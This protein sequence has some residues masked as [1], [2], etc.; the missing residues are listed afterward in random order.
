MASYASQVGEVAVSVKV[1]RPWLVAVFSVVTFG[2]YGAVWYYRVNRE[3]RDFGLAHGD[4]G[5][6][7]S[8]PT[9]SVLAITIGGIVVVPELVS[10][11]RIVGRLREVERIGTGET[12]SGAGLIALLVGSMLV[13]LA[14]SVHGAPA[15][16]VLF[17]A[18]GFV[19]AF[20]L[21]QARLNAVWRAARLGR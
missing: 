19:I 6:A 16:L 5:L 2:I 21:I 17:G 15:G 7:Q 10:Y 12:R 1:R 4:D 9:R 11:V 13:S 14:R 3:M 8:S 20:A 18:A